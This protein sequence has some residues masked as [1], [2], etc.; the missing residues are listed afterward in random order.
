MTD[1]RAPSS[2]RRPSNQLQVTASL[3]KAGLSTLGVQQALQGNIVSSPTDRAAIAK[4]LAAF[5]SIP[6]A[7]LEIYDWPGAY[8]QRFDGVDKGGGG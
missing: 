4:I 6:Q 5:G 8:A 2:L 1:R 7:L 3:Q